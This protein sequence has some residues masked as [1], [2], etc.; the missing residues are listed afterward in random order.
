MPLKHLDCFVTSVSDISSL[1]DCK[2]LTFLDV[3]RT[4]VT[5]AQVA[6]LQK[7]LPTCK[8]EWDDP[9]KVPAKS[10]PTSTLPSSN[11]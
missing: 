7:A 5:P 1:E 2:S 6:A 8:I 3:T 11:G 4:K 10:S 9:A